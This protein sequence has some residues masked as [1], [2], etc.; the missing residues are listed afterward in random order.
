VPIKVQNY[1]EACVEDFLEDILKNYPEIC[2][3]EMCKSDI[4]AY[5]LNRLPPKYTT[6]YKGEVYTRSSVLDSQYRTDVLSALVKGIKSV[7]KNPRH[8]KPVK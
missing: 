4:A 8:P 6:T 1:M 3:C 7:K 5:A 2:S